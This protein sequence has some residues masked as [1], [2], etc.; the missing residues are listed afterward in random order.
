MKNRYDRHIKLKPWGTAAQEQLGSSHAVVVGAGGLGAAVL[1]YLASAGVNKIT[2]VDYD[3]VSLSNLQRQVLYAEEDIGRL[4]AEV[5][6]EK[7]DA[8]NSEIQLKAIPQAIDVHSAEHLVKEA[9]VVLDCTDNF[10]TRYVINDACV[11][12]DIPFVFGALHTFSGQMAVCNYKGSATYRCLF[13]EAPTNAVIPNCAEIGVFSPLVALIASLMASEAL[14]VLAGL[15]S[16]QAA[17][18]ITYDL[19]THQQHALS[20][21]PNTAEI[22]RI[23]TL[24]RIEPIA[25]NDCEWNRQTLFVSDLKELKDPLFVD[26]REAGEHPQIDNT[27]VVALS[28]GLPNDRPL[29]LFC[30]TGK[31]ARLCAQKIERENVYYL[32]EEI[33]D[34]IHYLNQ[35]KHD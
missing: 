35:M 17:K 30:A 33:E 15:A 31:R 10:R 32:K 23:K 6:A 25:L 4:K 12:Q 29:V 5:A 18:L 9:D 16:V 2:I 27:E 19:L 8:L 24:E 20:F 26:V 1:P 21:T 3:R 11:R 22:E 14:K 28:E 13:K 7:L 34:F